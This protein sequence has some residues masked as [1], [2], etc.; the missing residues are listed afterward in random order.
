[1]LDYD[2]YFRRFKMSKLFYEIGHR[3][4]PHGLGHGLPHVLSLP[5][6]YMRIYSTLMVIEPRPKRSCS[7][8]NILNA[9]ILKSDK[10][11]YISRIAIH[12]LR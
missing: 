5:Q 10:I 8:A 12:S 3:A 2:E 6:I 1:M 9:T 7:W 4:L 11:D